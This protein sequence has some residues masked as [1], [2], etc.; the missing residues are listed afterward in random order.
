M[1]TWDSNMKTHDNRR[2]K[3]ASADVS[4]HPCLILGVKVRVLQ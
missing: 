2:R 4:E 1:G 3:A